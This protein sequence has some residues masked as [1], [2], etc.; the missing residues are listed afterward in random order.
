MRLLVIG[1]RCERTI[2]RPPRPR[3]YRQEPYGFSAAAVT[4]RLAC[5]DPP[6][7]AVQAAVAYLARILARVEPLGGGHGPA[8]P[9]LAGPV[10]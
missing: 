10:G 6:Q 5:G 8:D 7:R 1:C 2:A 9:L 3:S 4:A